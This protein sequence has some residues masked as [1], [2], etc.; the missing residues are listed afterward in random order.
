MSAPVQ[1]R[2]NIAPKRAEMVF[3]DALG[4]DRY[5][6]RS[7]PFLANGYA[8]GDVVEAPGGIVVS[9]AEPSGHR[10]VR[11]RMKWHPT[12]EE[13][14]PLWAPLAALGCLC[15]SSSAGLFAVDVPPGVGDEKLASEDWD[16]T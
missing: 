5:R 11:L 1:L 8:L 9:V 2:I 14:A 4:G 16:L 6:L 13:F 10:T 15:E 3:A 12:P 7:I